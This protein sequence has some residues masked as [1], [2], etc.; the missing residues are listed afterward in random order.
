MDTG[1][2]ADAAFPALMCLMQC[3]TETNLG[4]NSKKLRN[5]GIRVSMHYLAFVKVSFDR[6]TKR[7]AIG[8]NL[9]GAVCYKPL[10]PTRINRAYYYRF[11][12]NWD[13]YIRSE[14]Q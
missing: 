10:S 12:L 7:S 11:L 9:I 5:A 4:L 14:I 13:F 1:E 8:L 2:S 3:R 6:R